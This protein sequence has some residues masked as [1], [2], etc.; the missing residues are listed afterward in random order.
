MKSVSGSM[1][2][3]GP[4]GGEDRGESK[5]ETGRGFPQGW[6][7]VEGRGFINNIPETLLNANK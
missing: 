4:E 1:W 6:Q 3:R 5:V 2:Q 7:R